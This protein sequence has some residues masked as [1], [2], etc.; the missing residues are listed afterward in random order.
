MRTAAKGVGIF[1][2]YI[3]T[4]VAVIFV[5]IPLLVLVAAG[6]PVLLTWLFHLDLFGVVLLVGWWALLA[7]AY[8]KWWPAL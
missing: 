8:E 7:W 1:L 3:T 2:G 4:T 6:P 5:G